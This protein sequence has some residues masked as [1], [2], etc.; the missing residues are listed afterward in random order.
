MTFTKHISDLLYRYECVILPGFGAFLSHNQPARIDEHTHTF[1]PPCKQ[2][3]FNKQLQVND[4]LLAN[5]IAKLENCSYENALQKIRDEVQ[6]LKSVLE[7]DKAVS[8]ENIGIISISN[9]NTI[10]EPYNTV[11]FLSDAFGLSSFVSVEIP[12]DKTVEKE[13]EVIVLPVR[14]P[15]PY[16]KYAAIG[17]LALGLSGFGSMY[18]LNNQTA[19]YN[20]AEKQKATQ[21]LESQIQQA[22]FVVSGSLPS[23]TISVKKPSGKYHIVAGAFRIEENALTR[24]DEL[25]TKGYPARSL[26]VTKYGLHQVVYGSFQDKNE[27]LSILRS[28]QTNENKDA[29]LLVQELE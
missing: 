25:K 5:H 7:Q 6:Q 28:V 14:K 13:L 23:L 22:T 19:Q 2:L 16:I 21:Q 1:Y 10:F 20:L 11:N 17:L 15:V 9:G 29:W 26:G 12:R 4:G 27:A 18:Y 3:S 24:I 8:F